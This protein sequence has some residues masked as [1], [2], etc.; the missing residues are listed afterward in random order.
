MNIADYSK[1]VFWREIINCMSADNPHSCFS[2]FIESSFKYFCIDL[3][4]QP[5][6]WKHH[7][8]EG[9]HRIPSH[10]IY[11]TYRI[12]RSYLA[13][14]IRIAADRW[15]KVSCKDEGE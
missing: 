8:I 9:K 12:Y 11:I 1:S 3:H 5:C 15:K 2:C 7:N 6:S 14:F 4:R 10:C 13:K